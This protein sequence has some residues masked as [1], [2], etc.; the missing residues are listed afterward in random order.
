LSIGGKTVILEYRWDCRFSNSDE[1]L[2]ETGREK[3]MEQKK[4]DRWL[5]VFCPNARCLTEEEVAALPEE[6][7]KLAETAGDKGLWLA[8]EWDPESDSH[9]RK[10]SAKSGSAGGQEEGFWLNLFCP[11]DRCEVDEPSDL[12]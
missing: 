2:K 3:A 8:V 7:R 6:K 5:K 11:D 4:Q 1:D 9:E 10:T 12:P